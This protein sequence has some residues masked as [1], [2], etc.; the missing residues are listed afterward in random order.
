[1]DRLQKFREQKAEAVAQVNELLAKSEAEKR[2]ELTDE[3]TARWQELDSRIERLNAR[4]MI[5]ERAQKLNLEQES[6]NPRIPAEAVES[7]EQEQRSA[8]KERQQNGKDTG[9]TLGELCQGIRNEA[10]NR[11]VD[12]RFQQRAAVSGT[13]PSEGGYLLGAQMATDLLDRTVQTGV[14]MNRVRTIEIGP[15]FNSLTFPYIESSSR[16]NGSRFGGMDM[17]WLGESERKPESNVRWRTAEMKLQKLGGMCYVP[18]ELLQDAVALESWIRDAFYSEFGF[19]I[20]DAILNGNGVG[21]PL[22]IRNSP[23]LIVVPKEGGQAA[24]TLE[25]LNVLNMFSRFWA[26]NMNNAIWA[27]NTT[28]IPALGTMHLEI[29]TGG[30]PVY[31]PSGGVSGQMF[32]TLFARP[33]EFFEQLPVLGDEGDLILFDPREY[34]LIRKGGVQQA[35]SIHIHFDLDE[36]A[37]RFVVRL[38]GMPLWD[39]PVTPLNGPTKSPFVTLEAR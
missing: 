32:Q 26:A 23:A 39:K 38:N 24:D 36:T 12:P 17:K 14:L 5:E 16:L 28:I 21:R 13:V 30:A 2:A 7:I 37:F 34:L 20:D 19:Q 35:T 33:I 11:H 29:G 6:S 22:G 4:I 18:D 9:P 3:E 31:L 15:N 25:Y 27:A 8:R 10:V 1:M